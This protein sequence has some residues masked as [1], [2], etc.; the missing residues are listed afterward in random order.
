MSS[1]PHLAYTFEDYVRFERDAGTK[2][3]F[4]GGLILAMAGGTIEHG[5]LCAAVLRMLGVR[6]AEVPTTLLSN[7]P[8]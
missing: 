2:H 8:F 7:T 5:A 1:A 4:V 3:E 6:V